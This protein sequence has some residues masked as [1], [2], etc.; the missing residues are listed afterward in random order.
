MATVM[1]GGDLKTKTVSREAKAYLE[2][3]R[4]VSAAKRT[5]Q[6]ALA[7]ARSDPA[8]AVPTQSAKRCPKGWQAERRLRAYELELRGKN[9]AQ[10]AAEL[11]MSPSVVRHVLARAHR[12]RR[13]QLGEMLDL[14]RELEMSRAEML[15]ERFMA[16]ALMDRVTIRR[17]EDREPIPHESLDYAMKAAL[18]VLEVMKF[19]CKLLGLYASPKLNQSQDPKELLEWLRGQV[20]FVQGAEEPL[21][22]EPKAEPAHCQVKESLN[23]CSDESWAV[24]PWQYDAL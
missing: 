9:R 17:I 10:I 24:R 13:A 21:T 18:I 4:A 1:H 8:Q 20:P 12:E 3:Q 23:L 11:G 15:I 7:M 14:H 6:R 5:Q 19:E 2:H 22:Q 16:I